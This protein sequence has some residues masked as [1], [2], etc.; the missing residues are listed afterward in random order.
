MN[1]TPEQIHWAKLSDDELREIYRQ[2]WQAMYDAQ[3]AMEAAEEDFA[4]R[5][6]R[7][8]QAHHHMSLRGCPHTKGEEI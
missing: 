4:R 5:Q 2:R 6:A 1:E 3:L 7:W 8:A